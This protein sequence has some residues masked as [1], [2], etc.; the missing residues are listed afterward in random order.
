MK[1]LIVNAHV[2]SPGVEL[3]KASVVIEKGRIREVTTSAVPR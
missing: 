3:K 2:V 1:T